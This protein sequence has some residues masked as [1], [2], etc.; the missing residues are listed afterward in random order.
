MTPGA[1]VAAEPAPLPGPALAGG[2]QGQ[3][4]V[5]SPSTHGPWLWGFPA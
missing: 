4:G 2:A 5:Y 1:G 3:A